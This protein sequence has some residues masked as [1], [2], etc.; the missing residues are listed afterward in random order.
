MGSLWGISG[1]ISE[2]KRHACT[3]GGPY[4]DTEGRQLSASQEQSPHQELSQLHLDCELLRLQTM[5]NTC[6]LF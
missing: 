2:E 3:K 4:E 6:L 1:L 5:I